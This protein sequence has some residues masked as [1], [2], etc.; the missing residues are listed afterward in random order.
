MNP[1]KP[2]TR[3]LVAKN[4][5]ESIKKYPDQLLS[6]PE[7]IGDNLNMKMSFRYESGSCV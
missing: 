6:M 1:G 3:T 5:D 2:Q 7:Y 4:R